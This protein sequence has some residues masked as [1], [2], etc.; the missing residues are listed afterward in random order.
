MKLNA[1]QLRLHDARS[2]KSGF[3]AATLGAI[4]FA[5]ANCN[6]LTAT[7][8]TTEPIW[9]TNGWQ[10]STP[11]EQGMDSRQLIYH[12]FS[13]RLEG[14]PRVNAVKGTWQRENT[15]LME[16]LVLGL[17]EPPEEWTL[18]FSGGTLNLSAKFPENRELYIEG[19]AGG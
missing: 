18:M 11:E 2:Y 17:G 9:P 13:D 16:R 15:F 10:T 1:E 14:T 19:Q 7:Q 12:G 5:A 6:G 4:T 8:T 3:L